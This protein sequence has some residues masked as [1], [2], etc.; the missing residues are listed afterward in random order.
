MLILISSYR[1][2]MNQRTARPGWFAGR[3]YTG[4]VR[5]TRSRIDLHTGAGTRGNVRVS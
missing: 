3:S 1:G 4:I 2:K 5:D